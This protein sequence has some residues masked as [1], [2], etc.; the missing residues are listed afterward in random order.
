MN[1][2]RDL[3]ISN[4]IVGLVL[5]V[6]LAV[7]AGPSTLPRLLSS[8]LP[9]VVYEGV[10]CAWLRTADDR[11]D[12][13]SLLGR[14]AQ[15]PLRLRVQTT[16]IPRDASGALYIQITVVNESLGTIPIVYN[17]R[18]VIVGDNGTNGLGLLFVPPVSLSTG[19][20]RNPTGADSDLRLLGPRQ[21]CVH[22]VEFPA[23]N[24]LVDPALASGQA[25]V[26]AYYR[27]NTVGA[28]VQEPGVAATP[29]FRDQGLWIG[30]V[31]SEPVSIPL[32]SQ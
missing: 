12:H 17:P 6:L 32:A 2:L 28:T 20:V 21:R 30:Y 15:N 24:V 25:S 18:S 9:G 8:V 26:R 3:L 11:A 14:A 10:P 31:E 19:G 22:L 1:N 4:R 13:Q 5:L 7:L 27:N 29:I 16:A 23:G